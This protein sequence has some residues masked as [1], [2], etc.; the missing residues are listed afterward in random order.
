MEMLK[1]FFSSNKAK[2]SYY[3]F[4][5]CLSPQSMVIYRTF[6]LTNVARCLIKSQPSFITCP[7]YERTYKDICYNSIQAWVL[8]M[9]W[10]AFKVTKRKFQPSRSLHQTYSIRDD[11]LFAWE[12]HAFDNI[13]SALVYHSYFAWNDSNII[14]YEHHSGMLF[15]VKLLQWVVKFDENVMDMKV[16]LND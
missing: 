8:T 11:S 2:I 13:N 9:F 5:A 3:I 4:K 12:C 16:T 15:F 10:N 14:F 6:R 7:V 1:I